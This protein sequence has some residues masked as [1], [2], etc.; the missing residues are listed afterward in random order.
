M[1]TSEPNAALDLGRGLMKAGSGLR[2]RLGRRAQREFGITA[3]QADMLLMLA[4]HGTMI[5]TELASACGV[6]AST[7]THAVDAG[8]E[9]GL[10]RRE[11]HELDRRLVNVAVTPAGKRMAGRVRALIAD[12]ARGALEGV[13][14]PD[15][16]VL[17]ASLAQVMRNLDR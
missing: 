4:A 17:A 12:L 14:A 8:I 11:R 6:N 1:K 16:A 7:V 9:R 10:M 15:L 13:N 5:P 3:L 2:D